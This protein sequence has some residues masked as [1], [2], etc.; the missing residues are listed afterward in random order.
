[1]AEMDPDKG[2][3]GPEGEKIHVCRTSDGASTS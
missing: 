1:M 3:S 2:E